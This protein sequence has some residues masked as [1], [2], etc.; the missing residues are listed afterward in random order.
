MLKLL[1][2]KQLQEVFRSYFYDPKKNKNRS[3]GMT[4][5][6]FAAFALIMLGILGGLF[7]FLAS[8]LCGPLC[9]AQMGWLY[10]VI[11]SM[12]AIVLGVFGSVFNTYAGLYM[13]KDNDLLL[14]MPIPPKYI[15][16]S[17]LI[18]VYLLGLMYSGVAILPAVIVYWVNGYFSIPALVG[19]IVLLLLISLFVL[20]LSCVL[21]YGVARISLKLKNKSFVSVF[22][23]LV[24]IGAYYFFYFKASS[25]IQDL[26]ENA[27]EYGEKI[28]GAA[29]GV[30]LFGRIGEGGW[31]AMLLFTAVIAALAAVV[32][33]ILKKSF[34]KITT[35]AP[36]AKKAVYREKTARQRSVTGALFSRELGKYTSSA[37]YM[38]N[39]SLGVIMLL[40]LGGF[41]LFK[42][43]F[44][45]EAMEGVFG[46]LGGFTMVLFMA[47]IMA[48]IS[49]ND[50]AAPSVSLEGKNIWIAQSLPVKPFQVIGAKIL[51]QLVI[52]GVPTV[53]CLICFALIPGIALTQSLMTALA[54]LLFLLLYTLFCM[55]IGLKMPNLNWTNE[56]VPIKQSM[57]VAIPMFSGMLFPVAVAAL[58]YFWG[59]RIGFIAYACLL[60]LLFLLLSVVLWMW[61]KGRGA[62]RFAAL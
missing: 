30:Y 8:S 4:I 45:F 48:M 36:A 61:L 17:R 62:R 6:M 34:L 42:G 53:F 31:L 41:L 25:L 56:T 59:Y 21:G 29:Y 22:L 55:F 43:G 52:S 28:K 12:T 33:A 40:A 37:N 49:V 7:S 2:H 9:A 27:R 35:T 14:S 18:N 19:G 44:L 1:V 47:F 10:F 15:I 57:A 16:A 24:F 5:L 50:T 13:A 58:Y 51:L 3:K 54:C 46:A 39:C 38:L 11:M 26:I 60:S 20:I 23:S 32:W